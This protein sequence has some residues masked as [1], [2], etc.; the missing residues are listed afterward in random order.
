MPYVPEDFKPGECGWRCEFMGQTNCIPRCVQTFACCSIV[1][2][3]DKKW[4][5][6]GVGQP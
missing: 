4:N 2:C 1:M 6:E 3:V 5:K